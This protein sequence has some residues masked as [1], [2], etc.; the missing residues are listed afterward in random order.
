MQAICL[1]CNQCPKEFFSF[2]NIFERGF[3]HLAVFLFQLEDFVR[4]KQLPFHW[5]YYFS[6][7][8]EGM[9]VDFPIKVKPILSWSPVHHYLFNGKVRE[10]QQ[11]ALEN[12]V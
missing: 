1:Q 7:H 4:L 8:V 5:W 10:A 3:R 11:F 12:F 2:F 9:A 6:E